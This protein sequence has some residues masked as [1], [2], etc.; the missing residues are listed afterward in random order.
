MQ[1]IRNRLIPLLLGT[2]LVFFGT[3]CSTMLAVQGGP[4]AYQNSIQPG[5]TVQIATTDG[6]TLKFKV[7]DV[8]A[9]GLSGEGQAVSYDSIA[10]L[11]KQQFSFWRTAFL[12]GGII[13]AGVLAGGDGYGDDYD[14]GG[15]GGGGGGGPYTYP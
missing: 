14:Y 11:Q 3:G 10:S 2:A 12:V 15:R 5:D 6:R 4:A 13:A 8:N 9:N 1:I 7:S